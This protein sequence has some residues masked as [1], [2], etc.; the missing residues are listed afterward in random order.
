MILALINSNKDRDYAD[1][2]TTT[3]SNE[4]RMKGAQILI[5]QLIKGDKTMADLV[6]R[7]QLMVDA[8]VQLAY[9]PV[10][11]RDKTN[12]GHLIP[13]NCKIRRLKNL[14]NV[15]VPTYS[16]PVRVNCDYSDIVGKC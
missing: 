6:E 15:L 12:D 8:L 3:D 10:V 13:S 16:L 5:R 1:T 7:M 2:T 14:D 11:D 4:S 9:L